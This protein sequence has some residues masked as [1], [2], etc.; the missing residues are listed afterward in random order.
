MGNII[1]EIQN[2]YR[3][4]DTSLRFIFVNV[5]IF[6]LT[7]LVSITLALFNFNS[8]G[9]FR[10]LEL[11]ASITRLCYQPWA[12]ITYMFMH[13]NLMHLLF[14][15]LW[16]YCFGRLFLFFFSARHLRGLYFF[17]G[18]VGGLF[19]ILAYNIFPYFKDSVDYSYLLGAS[20]SVLAVSIAVAV[21]SPEYKVNFMFIGTVRLKYI[22]LILVI[23]DLMMITSGNAGGHISHLGGALGGWL[24]TSQL[25]KGRDITAWINKIIDVCTGNWTSLRANRKPKM[26]VHYGKYRRHTGHNTQKKQQNNETDRILDKLKQSGYESLTDEE[27]KHLF[28]A[29]RK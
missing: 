12:L 25:Q 10:W 6:L 1:S 27:K 28:D 14:N 11:P 20:A 19:Y 8:S 21:K 13:A 24:F 4:G 3:Q 16:L 5:G 26:K 22:A 9:I 17:G 29:G 2:R 23:T 7:A 15:M 18:I